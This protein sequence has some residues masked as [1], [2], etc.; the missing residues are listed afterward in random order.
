M[1][2]NEASP[3]VEP[4]AMVASS[5]QPTPISQVPTYSG[6]NADVVII[7]SSDDEDE[8]VQQ[9]NLDA[10]YDEEDRDDRDD[11]VEDDDDEI[12]EEEQE[13]DYEVRQC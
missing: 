12:Q 9:S 8:T 10:P 2:M 13:L 5:P 3:S 4:S 6:A 11:N 7:V 1:E